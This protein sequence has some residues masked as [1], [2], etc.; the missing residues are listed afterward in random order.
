MRGNSAR[1][2]GADMLQLPIV[3]A[4]PALAIPRRT[5]SRGHSQGQIGA[6]VDELTAGL[7]TTSRGW[8]LSTGILETKSNRWPRGLAL[9]T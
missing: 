3:V 7:P 6:G 4:F 2:C 8:G 9:G 5:L 1:R